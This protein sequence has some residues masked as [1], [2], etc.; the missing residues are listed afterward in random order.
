ML[1]KTAK[2]YYNN[3]II[4]I[5]EIIW[6]NNARYWACT[7]QIVF[8]SKSHL[9]HYKHQYHNPHNKMMSS[10]NGE[11]YSVIIRKK[12]L[13]SGANRCQGVKV[14]CNNIFLFYHDT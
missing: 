10:S 3:R 2:S 5:L 9:R 4:S 11:Q 6:R 12:C 13:D 7:I 8:L 14:K 1:L